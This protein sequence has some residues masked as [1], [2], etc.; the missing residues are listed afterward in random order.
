MEQSR[1]R[2][3][4]Y[5]LRK[6]LAKNEAGNNR[7]VNTDAIP[8]ENVTP[9]EKLLISFKFP[10]K[11]G[12]RLQTRGTVAN[13]K[14]YWREKKRE[15]RARMSSQ[16]KRRV[17]EKDRE[18]KAM[19]RKQEREMLTAV[20]SEKG[21]SQKT[22]W[23]VTSKI[24]QKMPKCPK[25]VVNGLIANSTPRK[26][27]AM[28]EQGIIPPAK[29]LCQIPHLGKVVKQMSQNKEGM[30]AAKLLAITALKIKQ[31]A[32]ARLMSSSLGL[33]RKT[34]VRACKYYQYNK[35]KN[36]LPHGWILMVM[37]FAQ[38]R[39]VY[40]QDEIKSARFAQRQITMHPIVVYRKGDN[41]NLV[42]ESLVFLSDDICHDSHAVEFYLQSAIKYLENENVMITR[43]VI[44]SDG[45]ASQYKGKVN[46]ADLSLSIYATERNYYGSEHGKGEGNGETGVINRAIDRAILGRQV[47]VRNV[48]EL[49]QWCSEHLS[50][51]TEF[52]KRKFF[53]VKLGDVSRNRQD[54]RVETLKGSRKLHKIKGNGVYSLTSNLSVE[55]GKY[56]AVFYDSRP[57]FGRIP[58]CRSFR[59]ESKFLHS[60][61]STSFDWPRRDDI[62]VVKK[63]LIFFGPIELSGHG[64]FYIKSFSCALDKYASLRKLNK[65]K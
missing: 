12:N 20:Q 27:E 50:T 54:R 40:F 26:R 58:N 15:Q 48:Q 9:K 63:S 19:K 45:C 23:N 16:K 41:G 43:V 60:V 51:E 61:S 30:A 10:H 55:I 1:K 8:R 53:H 28:E 59:S 52:S 32:S 42:R 25:V 7:Q 11:S 3:R 62:A 35:L 24:R 17:R 31:R 21:I 46:F 34:I 22:K 37:D 29:K 13:Q 44:F 49:Y 57:Y 5:R 64:P 2:Q 14:E 18:R 39:K 65:L 56:Y 6:K 47:I 33:N 36:N 4:E 38:N